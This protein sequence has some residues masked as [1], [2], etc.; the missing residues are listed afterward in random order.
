MAMVERDTDRVLRP[1]TV[2]RSL[3]TYR[4]AIAAMIISAVLLVTYFSGIFSMEETVTIGVIAP[5]TGE[6]SHLADVVDGM[7]LAVDKLNKWGGLNGARIELIVRDSGSDPNASVVLFEDLERTEH[8]LIYLS[9]AC[10]CTRPLLPL[11]EEHRVPLVGIATANALGFEE[12]NWSFR[13]YPGTSQEIQPALS[14]LDSFEVSSLGI[15]RSDN[16]MGIEITESLSSAFEATGGTVEVI[17]YCCKDGDIVSKAAN[18]TDNE[19]I[20]IAAD[21]KATVA[22]LRAVREAG[23]TGYVLGSSAAS[24][25]NVTSMPEAEGM[26]VSAPAVYNQNYIPAQSLVAEFEAE[27][28]HEMSHF[29]V[30]GY[31]AINLIYG[32]MLGKEL[33]REVMREQLHGGFQ[34]GSVLGPI[35]V[36]QGVHDIQYGLMPAQVVEGQ[37]WYL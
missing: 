36:P 33:T 29:A 30:S 24:A 7:N 17:D 13:Y 26:Y 22:G 9:A 3:R 25:P 20:F 11:A 23:F 31:D 34:Y 35:I 8:P 14:I 21:Y 32:L 16:I 15:F 27:Y 10:S 1:K 19:A 37:L 5:L 18:L 12:S 2:T 6:S 4:M 28:G